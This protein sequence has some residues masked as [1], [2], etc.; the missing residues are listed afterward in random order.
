[1]EAQRD[2]RPR[3]R[4][5]DV[6]DDPVTRR[7]RDQCPEVPVSFVDSALA[8]DVKAASSVI[9]E[10]P[11]PMLSAVTADPTPPRWATTNMYEASTAHVRGVLL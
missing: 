10:V 4:P 8:R 6:R 11:S 5:D 9:S 2:H 3:R 7:V 1:M